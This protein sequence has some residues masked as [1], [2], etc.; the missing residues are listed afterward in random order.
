LLSGGTF[1]PLLPPPWLRACNPV[2]RYQSYHTPSSLILFK[3]RV[4]LFLELRPRAIFFGV[5]GSSSVAPLLL[6][7]NV[8]SFP[9]SCTILPIPDCYFGY[10]D[11]SNV[12]MGSNG[13]NILY[14]AR[15]NDIKFGIP[16]IRSQILGFTGFNKD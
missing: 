1:A 5:E 8:R 7:F 16:F 6:P 2:L 13:D 4:I 11:A 15:A 10:R 9:T 12:T 3:T 14:N